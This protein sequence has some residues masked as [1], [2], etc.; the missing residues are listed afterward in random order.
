MKGLFALVA[1]QLVLVP[2]AGAA[3][4]DGIL[5]SAARAGRG[6]IV[7]VRPDGADLVDLTGNETAY[8]ADIRSYSWSPDGSRIVFSSHR[9]GP[10]STEIYV[11]NADGSGQCRLTF[12][13]GHDSIFDVQPVSSPDRHT[14]AFVQDQNLSDS[15]WLMDADGSNQRELANVGAIVRRLMWSPDSTRLLYDVNNAPPNRIELLDVRTG[16][17]RSLTPPGRNDF[18]ASWSPDGRLIAVTSNAPPGANHVDIVNAEDGSR[19]TLS[20]VAGTDAA[21]SPNGAQLA[22]VGTR[23]F[24]KYADRYGIPQRAD[25]YVVRADGSGLH[26]LTGP[27]DED[28]LG[29]VA[30]GFEPSWWPDGSRLFFHS[31]EGVG[32]GATSYVVNVDGSCEQR[33][34][35][36]QEPRLLYPAWQPVATTLPAPAQCADL[37]LSGEGPGDVVGLNSPARLHLT[38]ENDGNLTATGIRLQIT[39]AP[40]EVI[41]LDPRFAC[42]HETT[43]VCTLPSLAAQSSTRIDFNV[44]TEHPGL[45][46]TQYAVTADQPDNSRFL[47]TLELDQSVLPCVTVGTK[48][49]DVLSGTSD[50]DSICGRGGADRIDGRAGND[51]LDA[52]SGDDTVL[53]GPGRDTIS[54]GEGKDVILA[55][56]GRR[57]SVTCGPGRDVVIADRLDRI[58]S[59]CEKILRR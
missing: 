5:F 34:G 51:F 1:I 30:G 41:Q 13:S 49:A 18:Y 39:L 48:L 23:G 12:H 24:P 57:D 27:L 54:T 53:G 55:R 6:G 52:G 14:I 25:V 19:H 42:S 11:M 56:D 59:D 28:E 31:G 45:L 3:D 16:T 35:P 32:T 7:L 20:S 26:R 44:S 15:I 43:L 40:D 2:A 22:F 37:R 10:S 9:D 58:A 50:R 21:W 46:K 33:F 17:R 36:V 29:R 8:E 38:V 4:E 47:N